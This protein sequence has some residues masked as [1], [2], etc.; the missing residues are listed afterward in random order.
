MATWQDI[1]GTVGSFFRLGFTGPRLKANSGA[2]EIKNATDTGYADITCAK[3]NATADD[4]VINS[5]AAGSGADQKLTL[6]RPSSGMTGALTLTLPATA[7]SPDQILKTDGSGTLSWASAGSTAS[8]LHS[9]V[10]NLAY[11]AGSTVSMFSLPANADVKEVHVIVDT[12]FNGSPSI[13]VGVNGGSASKY[14]AATQ[15]DLSTATK[16]MIFPVQTPNGSAEDLEIAY[17]A[18]GATSGV[19]RVIV[20]YSNPA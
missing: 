16:Y 9:D 3:L 11:G 6:K 5:A 1:S 10:T 8:D 13:S 14:V 17:S 18:G 12:A 2:L 20:Y 7:G 19:A 15:V 4:I